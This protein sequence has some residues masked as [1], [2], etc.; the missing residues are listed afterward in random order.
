[1]RSFGASSVEPLSKYYVPFM[2]ITNCIRAEAIRDEH[3]QYTG[4]SSNVICFSH[5][6]SNLL[7]KSC[8]V[9]QRS[10]LVDGSSTLFK[11][12]LIIL[13]IMLSINVLDQVKSLN[14]IDLATMQTESRG[15]PSS[16][17]TLHTCPI[18][19]SQL[20]ATLGTGAVKFACNFATAEAGHPSHR[21]EEV[22]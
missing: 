20:G 3:Q 16:A 19:T 17:S 6:S 4:R 15:D 11:L 12:P 2:I 14:L 5:A 13:S 10:N 9:L 8:T 18:P 7:A 1:M 22:G 21:F